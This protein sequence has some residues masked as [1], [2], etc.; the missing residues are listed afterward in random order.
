MHIHVLYIL[1][2]YKNYCHENQCY[3]SNREKNFGVRKGGP[4]SP[5]NLLSGI[6]RKNE[7]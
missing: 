4:L 2:W 7:K 6:S 3:A 5:A 1:H